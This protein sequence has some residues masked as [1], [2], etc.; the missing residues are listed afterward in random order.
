MFI[1]ACQAETLARHQYYQYV[2]ILI[3]LDENILRCGGELIFSPH[4]KCEMAIFAPRG[5][6]P[7]LF[8]R[9]V[10][11]FAQ[12][13]YYD[14]RAISSAF[15]EAGL[16]ISTIPKLFFSRVFVIYFNILYGAGAPAPPF[17]ACRKSTPR[18]PARGSFR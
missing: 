14:R 7:I 10:F 1:R 12:R 18:T 11:V 16:L 6:S 13:K 15:F 8:P 9:F 5:F 17:F 2:K 4:F 3:T